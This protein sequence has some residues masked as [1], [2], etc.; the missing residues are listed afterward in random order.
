VKSWCSGLNIAATSTDPDNPQPSRAQ[1]TDVI[2]IVA[3]MLWSPKHP[4][5]RV[6]AQQQPR[7]HA[8]SQMP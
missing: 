5:R 2:R 3:S 1:M 7:P 4:S 6:A 8:T